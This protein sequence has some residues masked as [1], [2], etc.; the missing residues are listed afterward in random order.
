M[1]PITASALTFGAIIAIAA[2]LPRPSAALPD[3]LKC[4]CHEQ[5]KEAPEERPPLELDS[6]LRLYGAYLRRE[7][8]VEREDYGRVRLAWD[9][10]NRWL[11]PSAGV[12]A[13]IEGGQLRTCWIGNDLVLDQYA[14]V[15]LRLNHA[16]YGDWKTGI[17][18][19][20]AY[21]SYHRWWMDLAVGMG[22]AA[23]VFE[24]RDYRNPFIY[25]TQTPESRFI[26]NVSLHPPSFWKGRIE[27]D[28]GLRNYDDFEYHG[29]D[30]NG[31]HIEP[32]L[33]LGPDTT[34]TFFYERRY[35]GAFI[36]LPTLTRVTWLVSVEHRF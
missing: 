20:N 16:E 17:N 36:S 12:E 24:E 14:A 6:G 33:H 3:W 13:R 30:D 25:N 1:R 7:S 8:A 18:Y 34:F 27:L 26:Y 28:L 21:I 29:F 9:S 31:Y 19:A 5:E 35:A 23:L 22:Y 2:L 4:R 11:N 15:S 32:M 10:G